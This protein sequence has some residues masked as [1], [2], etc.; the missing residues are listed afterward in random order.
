MEE[1]KKGDKD[2]YTSRAATEG[3]PFHD[4]NILRFDAGARDCFLLFF[5]KAARDF[6][7]ALTDFLRRLLTLSLL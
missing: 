2:I 7:V 3:A 1:K 4:V 6:V 5:K